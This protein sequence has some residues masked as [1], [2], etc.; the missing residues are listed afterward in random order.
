M[1][2]FTRNAAAAFPVSCQP[3]VTTKKITQRNSNRVM[4]L[5]SFVFFG[6][7][8]ICSGSGMAQVLTEDFN[9]TPATAL[10]TNG[11]TAHSVGGTNTI[12]ITTPSL[13]YPSHPGS[14]IGNA[15]TMTTSGEDDN[16]TF[17]AITSGTAYASFLVNITAAQATG[18]YFVGLLTNS[19]TF[20]IRIYA[21]ST[22][23]GFF[24]GLSKANGAITYET[25]VRTIGLTYFLVTNYIY[26]GAAADDVVN[27]WVNPALGG[28]EGAATIPAINGA[29]ADITTI[30]GVYVRQGTA[31]NAP[32][33]RIDAIRVG[34]TWA[35]VTAAAAIP[36]VTPAS[37]AGTVGTSFTYNIVASNPP[38]LSYAIASGTLPAG[39]SLNTSTGAITGT[40]TAAGSSSVDVTATNSSGPSNPATLSFTIAMGNQTI[41]GLPANDTR[42][43]GAAPYNLSAIASSGL[44]VTYSSLPAGVVTF[45]GNQVTIVG[46]GSTTI[47]ASQAGDANWNPA[48]DVTQSLIVNKASQ[49]ITFGSLINRNDVDPNFQLTGSASSGLPVTYT[50][51]QTPVAEIVNSGG[52]IDP[53]G[54]WVDIIAP[55]TTTI[56]ASQAGNANYFA[57]TPVPQS[58]TIINTSLLNQTI[59][60]LAATDTRTYGDADYQLT[61]TGGGSLNPVTYASDNLA[62]AT[63]V[64]VNGDMVHIVGPGSA[65]ITAS[66]AGNGSYNAAPNVT[67]ALTVNKKT[68]TV[69]NAS[70][71][72][73]PYNGTVA[74]TISGATLNG[75]ISPDI[76]NIATFGGVFNDPNAN[77][78]ILV[79][80]AL[81][82]GGADQGKYILTQPTGLTGTITQA[83]QT[84]TFGLLADKSPG[85][86]N[87][88]YTATATSLLPVS[89]SSSAPSVATIVSG[90]L[91]HIGVLGSSTITATQAGNQNYL[92]ATPVQQTQNVVPA[93]PVSIFANTITGTNP[94]TSNPYTIGQT[95][96]ANITVSGI[97]RSAGITGTN[98]NDRYTASGW[99]VASLDVTKYFEFTLTPNSGYRIDFSSFVYTG[100]ASGTGPTSFAFR[101]SLDGYTANIGAP[102]ATGTTISLSGGAYQGLTTPVT[103]RLYGWAASGAAGTFS[104]NSFIFNGN[105][106][107]APPTATFVKTNVS[108]CGG[109][110]DGT[111]TVTPGGTGPFTYSWTGETGSNHTPF[112]A[113]NTSTLTGLPIGYYNV[114][115]TDANLNTVTITGIHIENAFSVYITNSGSLSSSCGNTGSI[116]LYGNAGVL[117]YSYSL[118]GINYLTG[119]GSNTFI[120]LAAGSYTGYIKDAA[121]CVST[122]SITVGA[123]PAIVVSPFVR[124]A[125]SC[126]NDGSI[127]IYRSG[128]IPPYTYS[129]SV[130]AAPAGIF[131]ANNKYVNLAAGPYTAYV[132][133]SKGCVS[134]QSATVTQGAGLTLTAN[135]S[136]TST[137]VNDGTIQLIASGGVA[138]YT[139]SIDDG[140]NYQNSNT[141][142]DLS[143]N[144]YPAKV[145]DS[146]GCTG[147]LNVT[148]NLNQ[149][150]VTATATPA[151]SCVAGNGKIQ[152]FR[153]GGVGPYS[154][155]LD[156][157]TYLPSSTFTNLSP[158]YYV[159][160]VKDS[161][162]CV[163][164]LIDILV[165]PEECLA[166]TVAGKNNKN[167][168]VKI[169]GNNTL[170]V[171]AYPNPTATE[172]VLKLEGYT[173]DK[174]SIIVTD[175]M[176]RK[177][178]QSEINGK[179]QH[180]FGSNFNPGLYNVQVIQGNEKKSIRLV[181]E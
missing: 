130:G 117:P 124:A 89:Y 7:M 149:I 71:D 76:V 162:A 179:Q 121:G 75:V 139:Y 28:S 19:T 133:D 27:L 173:N 141:F 78:G 127:E 60:G 70:V 34:S 54:D 136:N 66:Q 135:K 103:F 146:K 20:P 85:D 82:L 52:T 10:T 44:T 113:G 84:I 64:G 144:S 150:V 2:I 49:T 38:I 32:T 1:K 51:S 68:L 156:G 41:S 18:D 170:K 5:L 122:K 87:F 45:T 178:Y 53:N 120:N 129:L 163:G 35:Q 112:T 116:L 118:D 128:G 180:K 157:N 91:V 95:V 90:S 11:W 97:G 100:Q 93:T 171:Y 3:V 83:S 98:A 177:I 48:P 125:S 131:Q 50:S 12:L 105:V 36:V 166:R 40:P 181:K 46:A 22:A 14:G 140:V 115:V 152:L 102:T 155:S 111:I 37:P 23:G 94:N 13:T 114:T 25:T 17:T 4:R 142:S 165:G 132:K 15:I 110:N 62:V 168:V 159:G 47:T 69:S 96:N 143:A 74:A 59:T 174:V 81:T 21:K 42:T 138:P 88:N 108:I 175:I 176:G 106:F 160:Y 65:T 77:T 58:Q 56:T 67:Q 24:F 8:M 99:N 134:S 161:K 145:K 109:T 72:T 73:R 126:V 151:S 169:P 153:T 26:N 33:P 167:N 137:C 43:Y 55:G 86:P 107:V 164:Q 29:V 39:L 101:S 9:Y 80:A 31:A 123:A 104:V 158:D 6:M 61:A 57:A 172:F 147:S 148:I 92:A 79:T 154:Y 16:R 30:T 63:I 119:P